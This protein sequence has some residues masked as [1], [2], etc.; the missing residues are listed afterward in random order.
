M[1]CIIV[2]TW[3]PRS[4][5]HLYEIEARLSQLD[6]QVTDI[7]LDE[8]LT[9]KIQ[10]RR[11]TK[12][13]C[14]QT[15]Y[16]LF[17]F[18]GEFPPEQVNDETIT[19][20][21][22]EV[23]ELFVEDIFKKIQHVSYQQIMD[24]IIPLSFHA[25]GVNPRECP[26][27]EKAV[28]VGEARVCLDE[29]SVYSTG[30]NMY[31]K[32]EE[33][34]TFD[35]VTTPF[36]YIVLASTYVNKMVEVMSRIYG[37]T[38]EVE[39]FLGKE[40]FNGMQE[41]M[42]DIGAIKKDCSE[43]YGKLLQAVANIKHARESFESQKL[44]PQEEKI[45]DI[46][47]VSTGFERLRHD[48]EYLMPLWSD[49]L[50]KNLENLD[51]MINARFELQQA[52]E[53]RNEEKEMKILQA[54]FLVGVIASILTLGAMPGARLTFYSPDGHLIGTGNLVSFDTSDLLQ[55]GV[56]AVIFSITLFVLFNWI[57]M[58]FIA[59]QRGSR[60]GGDRF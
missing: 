8:S 30:K 51:F 35:N 23:R 42:V 50:I 28:E 19:S 26:D 43:R 58:R 24:G 59:S 22:R 3:I 60:P 55:F 2:S 47:G 32:T 21:K 13:E 15:P 10:T 1:A 33:G 44:K 45:A 41:A 5:S 52:V 12:L 57:Y 9:F 20:F 6:V 29:K 4:Y 48:S 46:L 11:G 53:A 38:E 31:L 49:V 17:T 39:D 16:G 7:R 27:M 25:I 34:E 14:R 36:S 37:K 40:E 56:L 54:I 18:K